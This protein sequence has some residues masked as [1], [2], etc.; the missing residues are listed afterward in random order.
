MA[1]GFNVMRLSKLRPLSGSSLISRSLTKPETEDVVVLTR[2]ASAVTVMVWVLSPTS[3]VKC[4]TASCPTTKS[5]PVRTTDL[6]PIFS[7]RIS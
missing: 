6:K 7:T 4:T 2:G 1:P 3:S 5:I